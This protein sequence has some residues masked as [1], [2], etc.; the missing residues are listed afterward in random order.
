MPAP[1]ANSVIGLALPLAKKLNCVIPVRSLEIL[2]SQIDCIAG[3]ITHDIV[4]TERI[5]RDPS[6]LDDFV[7]VRIN[8]ELNRAD[9]CTIE[10][11]TSFLA[12]SAWGAGQL[13]SHGRIEIVIILK[14]IGTGSTIVRKLPGVVVCKAGGR[15]D[16]SF[17]KQ[18]DGRIQIKTGERGSGHIIQLARRY[19]NRIDGG[20]LSVSVTGGKT[21]TDDCRWDFHGNFH[22]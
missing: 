6:K 14:L 7:G 21:K 12:G 8:D 13:K 1:G 4:C 15:T 16:A 2:H 3:I 18:N 20:N 11:K 10:D 22:S 9:I 5:K 17:T 19:V